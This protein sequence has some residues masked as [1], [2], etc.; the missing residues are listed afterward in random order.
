MD[1]APGITRG[2]GPRGTP[3]DRRTEGQGREHRDQPREKQDDRAT[4]L[5]PFQEIRTGMG[6]SK[7]ITLKTAE[8]PPQPGGAGRGHPLPPRTTD[9]TFRGSPG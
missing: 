5:G 3:V 2:E 4:L 1:R 6:P 8:F 9:D 7:E